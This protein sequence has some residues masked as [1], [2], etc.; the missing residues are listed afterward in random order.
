MSEKSKR[1]ELNPQPSCFEETEQTTVLPVVACEKKKKKIGGKL[2]SVCSF[3]SFV[4]FH[5]SVE[6][7]AENPLCGFSD[8]KL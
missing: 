2:G 4:V 1:P 7:K 8:G 3:V 5:I 6:T